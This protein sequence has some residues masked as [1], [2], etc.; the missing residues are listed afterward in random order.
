MVDVVIT[1]G[2]KRSLPGEVVFARPLTDTGDSY[3][4]RAKVA[5]QELNGSWLLSPGMQAEMKIE[6]GK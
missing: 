1:R 3:M 6:L 5:N 2:E 4:V